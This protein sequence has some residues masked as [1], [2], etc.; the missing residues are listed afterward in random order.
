MHRVSSSSLPP[1]YILGHSWTDSEFEKLVEV[2]EALVDDV[3][4]YATPKPE[5]LFS[6]LT[7]HFPDAVTIFGVIKFEV[8]KNV[9]IK[10]LKHPR[11]FPIS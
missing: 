2:D 4:P 3:N 8:S 1:Y 5:I 9:W 10:K 11:I 6:I 7:N